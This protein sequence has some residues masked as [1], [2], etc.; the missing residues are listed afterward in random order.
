MIEVCPKIKEEDLQYV[1][2]DIEELLNEIDEN[3]KPNIY[4]V[5][6]KKTDNKIWIYPQTDTFEKCWEKITDIVCKPEADNQLGEKIKDIIYTET[7]NIDSKVKCFCSRIISTDDQISLLI[8]CCN[9][10]AYE[11]QPQLLNVAEY[12]SILSSITLEYL[13]QSIDLIKNLVEMGMEEFEIDLHIV[14][15]KAS[16][17]FM[18]RITAPFLEH[19]PK[20][21]NIF[22]T[23]NAISALRYEGNEGIGQLVLAAKEHRNIEVNLK[24]VQPIKLTES[25]AIR[26]LLEIASEDFKLLSDGEF[27]Y[28]FGKIRARYNT[29]SENLFIVDFLSHYTWELG[30]HNSHKLMKVTYGQPIV[31]KN[32]IGRDE[33]EGK[34][35]EVFEKNQIDN[36]A[37][38]WALVEAAKKQKHGTILAILENAEAEANRLTSQCIKLHPIELSDNIMEL[39]SSIDGAVLVDLEANIHAMG[40]ILDG[41]AS[42]KG[43]SS[44]GARY[45]S[46][47]RYVDMHGE[48]CILIVVSEDKDIELVYS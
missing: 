26:K 32:F 43:D 3:L 34:L 29:E 33:F 37:K 10:E 44:R 24:L 11:V 41:V 19:A 8:L 23:L 1:T 42:Q 45:N 17:N 39:V 47:I 30:H 35:K 38:L 18:K 12:N 20:S 21:T 28:G 5:Q 9:K 36:F 2:K 31:K 25:K 27:V 15:R 22:H 16:E 40:V 46:A 13:N 4:L 7:N 6:I 14:F 48:K